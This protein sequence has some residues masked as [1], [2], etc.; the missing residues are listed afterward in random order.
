MLC[1]NINWLSVQVEFSIFAWIL[2]EI[3]EL[4]SIMCTLIWSCLM[5]AWHSKFGQ[6]VLHAEEYKVRGAYLWHCICTAYTYTTVI[7]SKSFC[8]GVITW[9]TS[10]V[11]DLSMAKNSNPG[12]SCGVQCLSVKGPQWKN[13]FTYLWFSSSLIGKIAVGELCGCLQIVWWLYPSGL[14]TYESY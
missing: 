13:G 10:H 9:N 14:L 1:M 7:C 8:V 5:L 4:A 3:K 11:F 2:S 6:W 12:L